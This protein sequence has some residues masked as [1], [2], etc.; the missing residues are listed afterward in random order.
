R[1][2]SSAHRE[3]LDTLRAAHGP[4]RLVARSIEPGLLPGLG[5]DWFDVLKELAARPCGADRLTIAL[6]RLPEVGRRAAETVT[7]HRLA[8]LQALGVQLL[9]LDGL[10]PVSARLVVEPVGATQGVAWQ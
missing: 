9:R 7:Y 2:E 3:M 10:A 4:V 8:E 1:P 5:R 6:E